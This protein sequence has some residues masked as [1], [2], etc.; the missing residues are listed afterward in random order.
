[1]QVLC[2]GTADTITGIGV[3]AAS[4]SVNRC[5]AITRTPISTG[6][7]DTAV[8]VSA[9]SGG[10]PT[11]KIENGAANDNLEVRVWGW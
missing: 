9:T 11:L 5:F 10:K 2:G 6:A 3:A 7:E 1:M 4:T 8:D